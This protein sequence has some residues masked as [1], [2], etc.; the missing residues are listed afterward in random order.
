LLGDIWEKTKNV[1]LV[2]NYLDFLKKGEKEIIFG[3]K[4]NSLTISEALLLKIEFLYL[5]MEIRSV[6]SAQHAYKVGKE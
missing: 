5:C 6:E 1:C 3:G 4:R 2:K